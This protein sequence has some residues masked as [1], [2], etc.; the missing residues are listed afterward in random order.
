[1]DPIQAFSDIIHLRELPTCIMRP[2]S[3]MCKYPLLFQQLLNSY[4]PD[5]EFYGELVEGVAACKRIV[6]KCDEAQRRADNIA[7][8]KMLERRVE[9]WKG[10]N[11]ANFGELLLD[12]VV[13]VKRN[14]ID[15]EYRVFLFE[16]I[17]IFCKEVLTLPNGNPKVG[18]NNSI[19]NIRNAQVLPIIPNTSSRKTVNPLHL[20]GRIFLKSVTQT[21]CNTTFGGECSNFPCRFSDFRH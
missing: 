16:K 11:L 15:R 19:W 2:V 10:H 7:T 3:R 8:V 13:V 21:V 18:K 12:D 1:M 9:D 20:K 17:I 6:E 4:P 5:H 14:N